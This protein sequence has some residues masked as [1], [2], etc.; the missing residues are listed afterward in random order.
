MSVGTDH[1]ANTLVARCSLARRFPVKAM[2]KYVAILDVTGEVCPLALLVKKL[3]VGQE[4]A[5][6]ILIL[7]HNFSA[8][9]VKTRQNR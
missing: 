6:P 8:P 5:S 7:S 9:D 2:S 4:I 1:L 3:K